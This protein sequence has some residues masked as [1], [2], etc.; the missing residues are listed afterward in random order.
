MAPTVYTSHIPSVPTLHHERSVFTHLFYPTS[1]NDGTEYIGGFPAET[2]A[3][4]DAVSGATI[5]RTHL[6]KL[7]LSFA[8]GLRNHPSLVLPPNYV[9]GGQTTPTPI[10]RGDTVMIFSPNSIMYPVILYGAIAAGVKSTLANNAYL[11]RELAWQWTDS[12]ARV[13]CVDEEL[14]P[15]VRQMFQLVGIP[16]E[17]GEKRM[18]VVGKGMD[19]VRGVFKEKTS[20]K[21]LTYWEELL[22]VGALDEEESF[23]GRY[24]DDTTFLCYSSGTTGKPKGV[25]VRLATVQP[26]DHT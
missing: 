3:F 17:E 12:G 9:V 6:K 16:A 1:A 23:D 20:S 7:A 10:A 19:W 25:E 15:V 21:A 14:V 4:I 5:T 18:I 24:S 13:V 26:L 11:P 22:A 2:P 8:C